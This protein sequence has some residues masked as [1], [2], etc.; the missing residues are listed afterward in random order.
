VSDAPLTLDVERL[1]YGGDALARHDG[2]VVF[3]PYAAAGD[4]VVAVPYERR[5]HFLR[6]TLTT[7][8]SPGPDRVP[9]ACDVFGVCGGCQWQHVDATAQ[10]VAKTAIV[11]EQ[12]ARLGGLRDVPVLPTLAGD[13]W[14]YRARIALAIDGDRIGYRRAR[15]HQLIAIDDCPI[16]APALSAH[17]PVVR[18]WV[19]AL[20]STPERVTIAA[21]PEGVVLVASVRSRPSDADRATSDALLAAE[22]GVRGVVLA[23]GGARLTLGDPIVHVLPEPDLVLEVPADVFAQVHPAANLALVAT[24]L[25]FAAP[26]AGTTALDLYCGAGNF[27]LP[28]ARRGVRVHGIEQSGVAADAARSNASRLGLDGA[29]F[30]AGDVTSA[31]AT[32][33]DRSLDLVVLDPPRA[34]AAGPLPHIAACR[35]P[36]IVYVS[37]D[38]ATLARDAR[39]LAGLG[40]RLARV[41]PVDLF[42]QT[43]HIESVAEFLLT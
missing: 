15:S 21:A 12:L 4:R 20:R 34:G 5:P 23:G 31:L 19:A 36:R 39:A 27:A 14:R 41:Q 6:A 32:W 13:T 42:P 37:C 22:P 3:I 1:T 30:D 24:V 38:P 17:I 33:R 43:Y 8:L 28:L 2:Q 7:V 9:P 26:V 10:R 11:A 35:A 16:A 25:D 18:R 40:Y 29:T